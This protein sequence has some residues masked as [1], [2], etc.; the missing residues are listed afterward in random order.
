MLYYTTIFIVSLV[1]VLVAAFLFKA[2]IAINKGIFN[3]DSARAGG[4]TGRH[5]N[6]IMPETVTGLKTPSGQTSQAT[7]WSLAQMYP[8]LPA[9]NDKKAAA[10]PHQVQS[11][12][13]VGRAS[14]VSRDASHKVLR[15]EHVCKPFKRNAAAPGT[16]VLRKAETPVARRAASRPLKSNTAGKPWGW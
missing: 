4:F 8:V 1:A 2:A 7:A 9:A 15:L 14:K 6:G 16:P 12:A 11:R 3:S 13:S 10:W 5:Q